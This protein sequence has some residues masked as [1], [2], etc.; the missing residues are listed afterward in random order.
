LPLKRGFRIFL[1][2]FGA[3]KL[4]NGIFLADKQIGK[5]RRKQDG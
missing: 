1:V 5:F 3:G 4:E 2:F